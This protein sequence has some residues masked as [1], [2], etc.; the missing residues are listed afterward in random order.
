MCFLHC[1][2]KIEKQPLIEIYLTP[3]V[4]IKKKL[5]GESQK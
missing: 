3:L 2:G 5:T 1:K 4:A